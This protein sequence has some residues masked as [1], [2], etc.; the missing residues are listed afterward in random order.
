MGNVQIKKPEPQKYFIQD[1]LKLEICTQLFNG[2][3]IKGS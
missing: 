3:V 1:G 2:G